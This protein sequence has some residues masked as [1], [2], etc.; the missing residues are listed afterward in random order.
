METFFVQSQKLKEQRKNFVKIKN[1]LCQEE[2]ENEKKIKES[3]DDAV[4]RQTP[5]L[6]EELYEFGESL[7]QEYANLSQEELHNFPKTGIFM[8]LEINAYHMS[9]D[10]F[11][12]EYYKSDKNNYDKE[13]NEYLKMKQEKIIYKETASENCKNEYYRA[14]DKILS[15]DINIHGIKKNV[16][17]FKNRSSSS[18][19]GGTTPFVFYCQKN[20]FRFIIEFDDDCDCEPGILMVK[21]L[22]N[23]KTGEKVKLECDLYCEN[24]SKAKLENFLTLIN[25]DSIDD[26]LQKR[27]G[28]YLELPQLLK[29]KNFTVEHPEPLIDP[30][31][32]IVNDYYFK[33]V[34][35]V[36]CSKGTCLLIPHES[37]LF[38]PHYELYITKFVGEEI[39]INNF[40]FEFKKDGYKFKYQSKA[41]IDELCHMIECFL[42]YEHNRFGYLQDNVY[43]NYKD[44]KKYID[45]KKSEI[46]KKQKDPIWMH[47][48]IEIDFHY[49]NDV[50]FGPDIDTFITLQF[51]KSWNPFNNR[52]K[53]TFPY[54]FEYYGI[55]LYYHKKEDPD[56]CYFSIEGKY[57][58]LNKII[59]DDSVTSV[60]L[61]APK[62]ET[63]G[64]FLEMYSQMTQFIDTIMMIAV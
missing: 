43:Y 30:N 27:F 4:Y 11:N 50:Y 14:I 29:Q 35:K 37:G 12:S 62:Y 38:S 22:E 28:H 57:H 26:Y 18:L 2:L 31:H 39:T 13:Y 7:N 36:T 41:D 33:F 6:K 32:C 61:I 3:Y 17:Q 21:N 23:L 34:I 53:I 8:N 48:E 56:K 5:L 49:R 15:Y 42:D 24:T 1:Q 58:D 46:N 60:D 59:C 45:S 10:H 52:S 64:T 20:H 19:C 25:S 63:S 9:F 51:G 44:I 40:N 54:P 55:H 16:S 47:R